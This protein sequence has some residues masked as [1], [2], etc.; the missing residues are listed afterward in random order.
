[1]LTI[2]HGQSLD[3]VKWVWA[4]WKDSPLSEL[5]ELGQA[6]LK[7]N[8]NF[9]F[10][11][12]SDL[13]RAYATGQAVLDAQTRTP[14]FTSS[15]KLREQHF[16]IAEGHPWVIETPPNQPLEELYKQGIFPVLPRDAKFPDGE[17]LEDVARRAEEALAEFVVPHLAADHDLHIAITSHGLFISELIAA[18][19]RLDPD[20]RRDI[21]YAGL[22]NTAWTRAVVSVKVHLVD[23][24]GTAP[25]DV[26]HLPPLTVNIKD[27]NNVDHLISLEVERILYELAAPETIDEE[28][29]SA[30][31][32][33][34]GKAMA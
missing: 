22:L 25:I 18:L 10:I 14:P 32:F 19:L 23:P 33:F 8:T 21:S 4:G 16:G 34:G 24:L 11:Y 13:L 29:S 3:N 20:S 7:S 2:R 6:F 27:V 12:T 28:K 31:E 9:D 30:R 1:M 15:Q 5:A 26:D 17:S